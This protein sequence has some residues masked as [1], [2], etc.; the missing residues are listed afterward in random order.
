MDKKI[1][2]YQVVFSQGHDFDTFNKEI[3]NYLS[4]GWELHGQHQIS[5]NWDNHNNTD[6]ITI[7]Q[8]LVKYDH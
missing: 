2:E 5:V 3:T 1:K 8:T 7:S 6:C 4:D